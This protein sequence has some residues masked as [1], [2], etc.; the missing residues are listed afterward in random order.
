VKF[1][2]QLP[3]YSFQLDEVHRELLEAGGWKLAAPM[4][5]A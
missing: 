3:A 1:S 5:V 2:H 4:E